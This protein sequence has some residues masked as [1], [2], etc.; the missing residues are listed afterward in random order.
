M[1]LLREL[2]ER[3]GAE[4]ATMPEWLRE[5]GEDGRSMQRVGG[6]L[7]AFRERALDLAEII[8][9]MKDGNRRAYRHFEEALS[10]SDFP[11]LF[12]FTVTRIM[13]DRYALYPSTWERIARRRVVPDFRLIDVKRR[14]YGAG[15]RM[16]EVPE[17]AEYPEVSLVEQNPVQYRLKKFGRKMSFS[18]ELSIGD[19]L[20]ELG[21]LPGEFGAGARE[22]ENYAVTEQ[23]VTTTG[24]HATLYSVGNG[25]IVTGN[26][27]LNI[28]GLQTAMTVLAAMKD[29]QGRPIYIR[30][31][32][33]VVSPA[34][35]ITAMNILNAINIEMTTAGGVRDGGTGEQRLIAQNWMRQRVTLV[36]DPYIPL[37]ATASNGNTSWFLFADTGEGAG[38]ALEIAFLR[39]YEQPSVWL[40]KSDAVRVGG[41]DVDPMEGSFH[42]DSISYRV[43]HIVSAA[44]VSPKFT[45][46]S[47]GSGA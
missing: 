12:G 16:L 42:D 23:Y 1:T 30:A 3:R 22:T 45:V 24:P 28:A 21:D 2:A 35:E 47:N 33:L 26:P 5:S 37:V 38:A 15:G 46:A 36:V 27:V 19:V 7:P 14:A 34:L 32:T 39:G 41:G 9:D 40:K 6:R 43:R 8:A 10:V 31:V 18:F 17:L 29:E 20:D 4:D 44:Q 11:L 13:L 25:N